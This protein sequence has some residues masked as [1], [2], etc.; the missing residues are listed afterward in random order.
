MPASLGVAAKRG[1]VVQN[2]H[3]GEVFPFRHKLVDAESVSN[4]IMSIS[5]GKVEAW[6]G[7]T[8]AGKVSRDEL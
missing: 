6:D 3:T 1:L 7:Q 8:R 5:E 4:F 2:P